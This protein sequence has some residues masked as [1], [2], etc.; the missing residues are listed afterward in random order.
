MK[1]C[2]KSHLLIW[3]IVLV[4]FFCLSQEDSLNVKSDSI[5]TSFNIPLFSTGG[6]EV[7]DDLEQQDVSS[8]LMSSRDVF[9]QFASF[10]FGAGRYRMRGY[11][12][13]NLNVM[14]NGVQVNDIETGFSTW[15]S[16][17]GL[18][19]VTRYQETRIGVVANRSGISGVGGYTNIDSRASSFRKGTKLSY[20]YS[21]RIYAHR[22]MATHSTGMMENGWALTMSAS[23]RIGDQV[24]VPGTYFNA[25][26][27]YLSVDKN[28]NDKHLISFTGFG[29]P[30]EQGRSSAAQKEVYELAHNNYYNSLWG[31]QNGEVRN[32]QIS[33]IFRPMFILSHTFNKSNTEQLTT[34]VFYNFG[35]S[36]R[37]ALNWND[38]P[39]PRPDYYRYLPSYYYQQ[40][41]TVNGDILTGNW[42]YNT[43]NA[44]QINW[45][46][47]IQ[48][49]MANLY[50]EPGSGINTSE[51]RARYIVEN[52]I[53]NLMNLGFNT[54]YNKR[55]ENLFLSA[56]L[57]GNIFKNRK[58]KEMEDLLGATFWIDVD[59]FAENLGV[60]D[61]FQQSNLDSPNKKIY[62]GD[63]F[64]YDYSINVNKF[65]A[66]TQL[67][68]SFKFVDVYFGLNIGNSTI[69]RT[70]YWANGKFPTTSK[71]DSEKRNYLNTGF[72]AGSVFKITGRHFVT[73]NAMFANRMP[74][75]NSIFISQRVRNDIVK[76]VQ[77]EQVISGDLNYLIKYPSFNVRLTGYYTQFN[78]QT[79]VR[80]FWS[81]EFNNLVNYIMTD[82]NQLHKGVELGIEKSFLGAHFIQGALGYGQF[83]YNNQPK[84]QA[85]Q[86]NNNTSLFTDRTVYLTNY[87]MGNGPQFVSGIGYRFSGKKFWFA[88]I[89]FNYFDEIY[90]DPNPD[91][92]T[93]EALAKYVTTDKQYE[94]II[95]QEKLPSYFTI[96]L[97]AGKSVRIMKKY[98]LSGNLSVNNLLNNKNIITGGYEQLRWDQS[99]LERFP[100]K[101]YYMNG[102]T[103]M[104]II[105]FRF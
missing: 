30:R 38:A 58:Y 44:Q 50:S 25:N 80:S 93:S 52:R 42:L 34:S 21:N 102:L 92:R 14:I 104:A 60:D 61:A 75:A 59:Q 86:D 54:I 37:T 15:S 26:A 78:K 17:G 65:D 94:A 88:G 47:L 2:L 73:V 3:I 67:E 91:R 95:E 32:S 5:S 7:D 89:N 29:A 62:K 55:F 9:T 41:D 57:S 12:S 51:T 39:N 20:A 11:M 98:F 87:R 46:R 76:G 49:N 35:K 16:W 48:M 4:P 84:A 70:G 33:K 64:G 85:W 90:F 53:E 103:F 77:P 18:N 43:D 40:G 79:W 31:Y 13:E 56:G 27:F 8:L 10:Q 6:G 69:W 101:Y 74:E 105:N 36:S 22:F 19:D 81:D 99:N 24:Y 66:W 23:S 96:N 63:R 83:T 72:K 82:V 1:N 28:I 45:D 100:N 97:N 68:Y 71:G